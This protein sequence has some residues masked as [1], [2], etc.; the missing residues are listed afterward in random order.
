MPQVIMFLHTHILSIYI[1]R[2]LLRERPNDQ[3]EE[4]FHTLPIHHTEH[5]LTWILNS[6]LPEIAETEELFRVLWRAWIRM[7]ALVGFQKKIHRVGLFN[8]YQNTPMYGYMIWYIYHVFTY[9]YKKK[10]PFMCRSIFQSHGASYGCCLM[11]SGQAKLIRERLYNGTSP[12]RRRWNTHFFGDSNPDFL[13]MKAT[14]VD[15]K[16]SG[17]LFPSWRLWSYFVNNSNLRTSQGRYH[18]FGHFQS[19]WN[20][21][22]QAST[23][24]ENHGSGG[25]YWWQAPWLQTQEHTGTVRLEIFVPRKKRP[26]CF[27]RQKIWR[28]SEPRAGD[29]SLE[30]FARHMFNYVHRGAELEHVHEDV[31]F[32]IWTN[33]SNFS[34]SL[35]REVFSSANF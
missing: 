31:V 28:W 29:N 33:T 24:F 19:F 6:G 23:H 27:G 8:L 21:H 1:Y 13:D 25:L 18:Y 34:L 16:T 2:E 7:C 9:I 15:E 30:I 4:V 14:V 22:L 10:Q 32:M 11:N 3:P 26:I 35:W 12:L 5:H 17:Q 20:L